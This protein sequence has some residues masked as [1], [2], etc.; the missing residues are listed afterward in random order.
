MNTTWVNP[1]LTPQFYDATKVKEKEPT[2]EAKI[3]WIAFPKKVC[4]LAVRFVLKYLTP[5][6]QI[7]TEAGGNDIARWKKA[8]SSRD[9]QDEYC[10]W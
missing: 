7:K 4:Y 6:I 5:S 2:T 1:K 8:D 10:E 3:T 9:Y